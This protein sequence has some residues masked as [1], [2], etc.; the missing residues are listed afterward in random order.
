MNLLRTALDGV[1]NPRNDV[2]GTGR[3]YLWCYVQLTEE[4]GETISTREFSTH[5][6]ASLGILFP[7]LYAKILA[8]TYLE[9]RLQLMST[10]LRV[11][12]LEGPI[13]LSQLCAVCCEASI[14][15]AISV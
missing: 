12:M 2:S 14:I 9:L 7:Y 4:R 3:R 8:G 11:D 15:R 5:G 10:L 6:E 13:L 1:N